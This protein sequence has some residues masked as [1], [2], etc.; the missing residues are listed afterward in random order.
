MKIQ[1]REPLN[2]I[3][4]LFGIL[5]SAIGLMLLLINSIQ[6]NDSLKI[7]TSIIFCLGLISLYS[8]STIYHWIIASERTLEI[9]RK[10][11]HIMIYI[12][13]AAS[14]TPICI[15]TLKGLLGYTLISIVWSLAIL[16]IILKIVW[17]NAPRWLYTSFYLILGWAALFVIY[18]LYKL[19]PLTG[20]LLL[21]FGGISY[22]VGAVIYGT[23][24]EKIKI[25]KFG[26]H[27]IFHIFIL[28]GSIIHY[29]M[30]FKYVI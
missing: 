2:S 12:L 10:V 24:S 18:P 14:Y 21:V 15:I 16:G 27:E 5:L 1:I 11:D 19:L 22:S 8:A 3:T 13:I 17:L 25:W 30:I 26:F 6:T 29:I 4:H 9:L 20:F 23:K 28:L 7:L